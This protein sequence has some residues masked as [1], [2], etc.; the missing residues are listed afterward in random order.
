[1]SFT[2]VIDDYANGASG[3]LTT[4]DGGSVG[5]TVSANVNTISRAGS[6]R[7]AQVTADGSETVS[8]T[9]DQPVRGMTLS[10]NRSNP[11]EI[12]F[13]EIDGIQVDLNAA[14]ADGSVEFTQA[15][16]ATHVISATGGMTSTGNFDDGSLGFLHF[17]TAVTTV[18]I[19]GTGG[20]SGNW[21][22]IE[23][24]IDSTDFTAVCFVADT[25][26]A[27]A[28]GSCPVEALA[29]GDRVRVLDGGTA[30]VTLTNRRVF[31]AIELIREPRL[32][33]IRIAA[34]ALGHGLPQRDLRVS[35]QHRVLVASR[36]AARVCGASQVLV[37]A[38]RL[39][40]LPG[41]EVDR[42][43]RPVAYHHFA[44]ARHEVVF[45]EGAP[46]ESLFA[47]PAACQSVGTEEW[48]A[49]NMR[50]ARSFPAGKD[51]K[52]II[53]AHGLHD[54]SVLECL[55]QKAR[56]TGASGA[57]MHLSPQP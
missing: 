18:R 36:I 16:A 5:Y 55:R 57:K 12:Y 30:R 28:Q 21:D 29:V 10:F 32:L 26:I 4:S 3:T 31:T 43:L 40:A 13:V 27:T 23:I 53:A 7:G 52:K 9:F 38:L 6:D 51:A 8:V 2:D 17:T 15:G 20:N 49:Q 33:P 47:G 42:S 14:I 25:R 37:P 39:L 35:R 24:G 1:M 19:F 44:C 45:A 48:A 56:G 11:G 54:R 34:G 50:P 46:A 41:V 22:L